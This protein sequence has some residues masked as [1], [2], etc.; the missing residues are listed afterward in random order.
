MFET[1]SHS[2]TIAQPPCVS[3]FYPVLS[4]DRSRMALYIRGDESGRVL[5]APIG[6][7]LELWIG[8][9]RVHWTAGAFP[10]WLAAKTTKPLFHGTSLYRQRSISRR[11]SAAS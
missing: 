1:R 10:G 3:T 2:L 5:D 9:E 8:Y 7:L 6:Q 4:L 11:S